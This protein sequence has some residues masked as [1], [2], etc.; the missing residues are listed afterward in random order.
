MRVDVLTRALG[1][2]RRLPPLAVDLGLGALFAAMVAA[3]LVRRPW[4]G[5]AANLAAA[6]LTLVLAACLALRRRAP[7]AACAVA[8]VALT[9]ESLLGVAT[10]LSPLATWV[11]AYSVGRYASRSRARWGPVLI[12]AGVV[13]YFIGTPGLAQAD[14]LE[15]GSVL[16]VWLATWALG[17]GAARRREE[18]ERTR[19]RG[20]AAVRR[21]RAH[22]DRPGAARPGRAH[23]Q[24]PASSRPARPGGVLD[25][26][27]EQA[28]ELLRGHGADRPGRPGRAGPGPGDPARGPGADGP[29]ARPGRPR[30]PAWPSCPTWPAGSTT[31]GRRSTGCWIPTL[32]LPRA[33][34]TSRRTGS[35]RRR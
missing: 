21:R 30:R 12:V 10:E 35:S 34:W 5:V 8:V 7:L 23:G 24:P 3:E 1:R 6:V 2:L 16:L 26:D 28:R 4:P 15:L 20:R 27:P 25:R 29:G 11:S 14:L 22:P 19:R 13:G 32:R 9:T 18:Q 17:Y 33:A 31:R